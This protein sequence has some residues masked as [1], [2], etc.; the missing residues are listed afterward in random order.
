M[1]RY[2]SL[3]LCTALLLGFQTAPAS[4]LVLTGG[5]IAKF[6]DKDGTENDKAIIKFA[7]DPA[8]QEP[9]PVANCPNPSSIRLVTDQH[10][11]GVVPLGCNLWR[12]AGSGFKYI[13][14]DGLFGGVQKILIKPT[15]NG[16]TLLIKLK[17][18]NYGLNAINGPINYLEAHLTIGATDYC[19]R[20]QV[21]PSTQKKN[22][23]SKVI[24]KGPSTACIPD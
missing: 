1:R 19:G 21:P 3:V 5:R 10:D 6:L 15:P 9:L 7:R 24:F 22:D 4:G 11:I 18:D 23:L 14:K 16:G 17:G 12:P 8:I 13:D 2:V 20:F